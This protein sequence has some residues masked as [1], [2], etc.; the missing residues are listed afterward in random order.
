MPLIGSS[1]LRNTLTL[2]L[3][4]GLGERL[5]PLTSVRTKPSVPF[6][7]KYR[8]IDFALSNCLNSGLRKIY[9]L[10]QYKSDS[11]N[12][13]LYEAWNI[14]NPELGEFIYSVP[15][16][17]K[18]SNNWYL[19]TSN[20]IYQN[21]NFI[22]E[23]S[24]QSVL[25]LSG[26]HIYKMDY[27]KMLQYHAQEKADLTIASFYVPIDQADRY[28]IIKI[29]DK[30]KV[31]SFIEKPSNPPEAPDRPGYSF[32]NM[33]IYIFKAGVL[34]SVLDKMIEEDI[35][36]EDFGKHVIP[37]MI[38][39]GYNIRAY[40]FEDLNNKDKP[41]WVDVGTID[42]YYAASMD[43]ITV[44]PAFNLYDFSWPLRTK[45][46]QY[47]PAKTLSHEGERVGRVFNS[48]V[49]DG[50]IVSGG[51][52]ERSILGFNVRVNSYTYITDSIIF[53]NCEIGRHSR[54]RRTIVDKNV[55]IPEHTEIGFD[56]EEDKKK[57]TIS[58]TGIVV[59]PKGYKFEPK[60]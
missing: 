21:L 3:A 14:F 55:K 58:D 8:I 52:V 4:G 53:D 56:P 29:D 11:L 57:F 1:I 43:L 28:G 35:P 45:Q 22:K 46:L 15:P 27:L 6:G 9:V 10:T 24:V 23:D 16:Q 42:S 25:I 7:G 32:V 59:I 37:Y 2:I 20:A 50:T 5:K 47:P 17:Q 38:E 40:R 36:S 44:N 26:D 13:H 30:Y 41:Y 39:K 18:T 31:V 48:L 12:Q 19:G 34:K 51:L 33:G 54:I 49:S 60:K